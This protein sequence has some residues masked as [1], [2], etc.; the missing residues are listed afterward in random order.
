MPKRK[1][2]NN[3]SERQVYRRLA[4]Q[5]QEDVMLVDSSSVD[6][7]FLNNVPRLP[8]GIEHKRNKENLN[9]ATDANNAEYGVAKNDPQFMINNFADDFAEN[10]IN[11]QNIDKAVENIAQDFVSEDCDSDSEEDLEK[12]CPAI[13]LET[14]D[15]VEELASF[16]LDTAMKHVHLNRLLKLLRKAGHKN[17]PEDS[18]T[19]LQTLRTS[20]ME[21]TD[22]P[23]GT[24]LH[25]GLQKALEER[26][27][28]N[29]FFISGTEI[30]LDLNIDGLPIAK[31]SGTSLWP[32]L[33]KIINGPFNTPFVIG[34][35]HGDK[36][37]Y[38]VHDYLIPFI[39]EYKRLNSEGF[40]VDSKQFI[41][42]IRCIICDSPARSY[43]KCTKQFNGYFSCGM[44]TEEGDF[45]NRMVFLSESAPLRTNETFR[46]RTNEEHHTGT[47][48]FEALPIDMV[49]QFPLDYMH[50]VC[51]GVMKI[52]L[53]IWF[54]CR[55]ILTLRAEAV[56]Q[57]SDALVIS[58]QWIPKD[59]NRKPR[60][61]QELHRWKA[62]EFRTF[63]LYLGPI[64]LQPILSKK[65]LAHFNALS[66]A[67]RI[68]CDPHDCY[69]NNAYAKELLVYFVQQFKT[70]YGKEYV[71]SNV[72]NLIHL[73]ESVKAFGTLDGFSAFDFENHMQT[74]K[75]LLR[76]HAKP[77]QQIHRRLSE[78]GQAK[79]SQITANISGMNLN[80]PLV[81]KP[82]RSNLPMGCHREHRVLQFKNLEIS[83]KRPDNCCFMADG[84][85]V[86]INHI[87]FR[88]N[89]IVV[90]GCAFLNRNDIQNY[91]CASSN[92]HIYEVKNL[93]PPQIWPADQI[94][95][96]AVL[97]TFQNN[98][99]V[100]PLL[101]Q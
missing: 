40:V 53:T 95:R 80:Y 57:L 19:L 13:I 64:L 91:P 63:L 47:S 68:L 11:I 72:H 79:S 41:V 17:L 82:V 2:Y 12:D 37:P 101:H 69:V 96:K 66:C 16:A 24:Y 28:N 34:I 10:V 14:F 70:L 84:S 59:F 18:R 71:T 86:M 5:W 4:E 76:K 97:L 58:G 27:Q 29:T 31:S 46:R 99:Y 26:L 49:I 98:Q 88:G 78:I 52:L 43:V 22:C 36:K 56:Q 73:N 75:R 93:S 85:I 83:N 6:D 50:L 7:E 51:L 81:K 20:N 23:P 9:P 30:M 60:G 55:R 77:L 100:M 92:L 45:M 21:I 65:Y 62:T 39:N 8:M 35:Y 94:C 33:G 15:F 67:I 61:L 90:I 74:L 54:D 32:I 3:L 1:R 25:Y 87:A 48:P 38:S 42:T 44:C 89:V